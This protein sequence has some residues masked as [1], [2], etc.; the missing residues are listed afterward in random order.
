[1]N[2]CP[3]CGSTRYN[4]GSCK[5][6]NFLNNP[7]H[8]D[9][10]KTRAHQI[11]IDQTIIS[12]PTKKYEHDKFEPEPGM[13]YEDP[14]LNKTGGKTNGRRKCNSTSDGKS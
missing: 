2:N 3:A 7:N 14:N 10:I 6:C 8:L 9:K 5:K 13:T 4:C 11:K 1:M 12:G